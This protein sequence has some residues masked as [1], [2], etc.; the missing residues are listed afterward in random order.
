[1]TLSFKIWSICL[2]DTADAEFGSVCAHA[3]LPVTYS[4]L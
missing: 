1:M 3:F 2:W 4:F